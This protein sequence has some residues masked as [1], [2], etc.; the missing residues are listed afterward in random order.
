M[1][2]SAGWKRDLG[3]D[4][5]LWTRH[6]PPVLAPFYAW[7]Y[8]RALARWSKCLRRRLFTRFSFLGRRSEFIYQIALGQWGTSSAP[9]DYGWVHAPWKGLNSFPHRCRTATLSDIPDTQLGH[10][11]GQEQS[12]WSAPT[13]HSLP[14]SL[15]HGQCFWPRRTVPYDHRWEIND[16]RNHR[17]QRLDNI[18]L[19]LQ[20]CRS[21]DAGDRWD[22]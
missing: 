22:W 12:R 7:M 17:L 15:V 1:E 13:Y 14:D 16:R 5:V 8:L 4:L 10:K 21:S 11:C 6:A 2:P 20:A 19:S 9:I 18:L 3:H